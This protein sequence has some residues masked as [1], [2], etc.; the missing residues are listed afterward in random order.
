MTDKEGLG[1]KLTK[2][3][4]KALQ[5]IS[6]REPVS[7]FSADGPRLS[8]VRKLVDAGMVEV[9]GVERGRFGFIRYALSPAG[10]QA[11]SE[12]PL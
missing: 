5:W 10:R 1:V 12:H 3:Q 4:T 11:L 8:F 2:A 9:R 7:M 6:D